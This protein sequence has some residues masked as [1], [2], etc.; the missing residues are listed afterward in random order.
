MSSETETELPAGTLAMLLAEPPDGLLG[1]ALRWVPVDTGQ[2]CR[3][4]ALGCAMMRGSIDLTARRPADEP[5]MQSAEYYREWLRGTRDTSAGETAL[6]IYSLHF[7]LQMTA[8]ETVPAN[9]VK[10]AGML[11]NWFA[12]GSMRRPWGTG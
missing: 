5:A 4:A 3:I 6:R 11:R 7:A 1:L 9:V 10:A 2:A 8:P 12:D